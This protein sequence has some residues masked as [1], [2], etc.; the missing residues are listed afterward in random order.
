MPCH[1]APQDAGVSVRKRAVKALWECCAKCPGFSRK[2]DAVVAILQRWAVGGVVPPAGAT[3]V[4]SNL[5]LLL[6]IWASYSATLRQRQKS[7]VCGW[8]K[9]QQRLY[10]G[11]NGA[12]VCPAH[13]DCPAA[14]RVADTEESMRTLVTRLC[15]DMWF[16]PGASVEGPEVRPARRALKRCGPR[17]CLLQTSMHTAMGRP[18]C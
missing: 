10:C 14:R 3:V 7:G 9:P 8:P 6:P 12:L 4:D 17:A 18:N 5:K 15:G 16:V 1:A 11:L 2:T 13:D